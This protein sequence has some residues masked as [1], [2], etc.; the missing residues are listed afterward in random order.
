MFLMMF[1]FHSVDSQ[2]IAIM[3]HV[4]AEFHIGVLCDSELVCAPL[5]A[6]SVFININIL[7]AGEVRV[8]SH[9]EAACHPCADCL[10]SWNTS[11]ATPRYTVFPLTAANVYRCASCHMSAVSQILVMTT[12][13]NGTH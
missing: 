3:C 10:T 8:E 5:N 12:F 2:V 7:G 9:E 13:R 4:I 11:A 6:P 1:C